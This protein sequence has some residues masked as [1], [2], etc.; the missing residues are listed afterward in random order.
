MSFLQAA[1]ITGYNRRK[2]RSVTVTFTT[3]EIPDITEVDTLVMQ[4][5]FGVLFFKRSP[6][7]ILSPE[8]IDALETHEPDLDN[9]KKSPS[10]RLRGVLWHLWAKSE[11]GIDRMDAA[12]KQRRF[13]D[14]YN[15][16]M[17]RLIQHYKD[18]LD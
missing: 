12:E 5:A 15:S 10:K 1:Q 3:Q 4:E 13:R 2:D 17:E 6:D 14:F 16:E 8:E 11:F 18:K 9:P 7:G